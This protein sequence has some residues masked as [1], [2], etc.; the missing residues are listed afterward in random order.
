MNGATGSP[1]EAGST[2]MGPRWWGMLLYLPLLYGAGWLMARPLPLVLGPLRND[3]VDL[4]GAGIALGLLLLTL[5]KRLRRSLGEKQPWRR[6]GVAGPPRRCLAALLRGCVTGLLLLA[7]LVL[8]L[9]L[10]RS[11]QWQGSISWGS[12]LNAAALGAG[13]GFAEELVFRG[14]FWEEAQQVLPQR[15]AIS[16]QAGVFA[17]IHPWYR[18]PALGAATLLGGLI[19]LAVVLALQRRQERGLL[20]GAMGLHGALVGGFFLVQHGLVRFNPLSPSWL[21]GTGEPVPNPISGLVGWACLLV[22]I[23]MRRRVW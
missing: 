13:V 1:P 7:G 12:L 16:L 4:C 22:V 18:E 17:L 21:V 20:W 3:Q 8:V 19:L 15:W 10:T 2:G 5:P 6:L 14:W 23:W 11:G 9:V